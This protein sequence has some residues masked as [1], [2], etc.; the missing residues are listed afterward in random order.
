MPPPRRPTHH[1]PRANA[2]TPTA[3][4]FACS[5]PPATKSAWDDYAP[6]NEEAIAAHFPVPSAEI[7]DRLVDLLLPRN[8][9]QPK[10]RMLPENAA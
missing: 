7:A 2:S 9:T 3:A 4:A 6:G 8:L 10:A 5:V 1:R